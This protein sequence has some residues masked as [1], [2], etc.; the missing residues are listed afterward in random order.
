MSVFTA[1][2]P[3]H[4]E[5]DN[6]LR[7]LNMAKSSLNFPDEPV[8]GRGYFECLD[9]ITEKAKVCTLSLCGCPL[10]NRVAPVA[11]RMATLLIA[12]FARE[13]AIELL[14]GICCWRCSF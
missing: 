8:S 5:C 9:I 6:A 13:S 4:G 10:C 14:V 3:A 2:S 11:G 7:R 1:S 12:A